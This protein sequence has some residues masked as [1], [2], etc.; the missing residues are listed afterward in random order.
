MPRRRFTD[1]RIVRPYE[2]GD[3]LATGCFLF[4]NRSINLHRMAEQEGLNY[5]YLWRIFNGVRM[6]SHAYAKK[7]A[8]YLG[9]TTVELF[10]ALEPQSGSNAPAQE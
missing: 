3:E 9:M 8:E 7:I 2:P 6:P 1:D 4:C 10:A 5:S